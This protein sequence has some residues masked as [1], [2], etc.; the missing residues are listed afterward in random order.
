MQETRALLRKVIGPGIPWPL[1]EHHVHHLRN[2]VAGA[3][4]DDGIA[5][6]DIAALAQLFA[7]AADSPDV[8]VVVQRDVLHDDAADA[9]RLELSDRGERAGASDLDLD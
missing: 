6:P 2:D 1:V 5:D 4:D 8:V 3:L 9:D 7:V